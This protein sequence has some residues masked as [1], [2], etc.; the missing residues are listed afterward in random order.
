M[1]GAYAFQRINH[2][3]SF[4]NKMCFCL[5]GYRPVALTSVAMTT[6][7]SFVLTHLESLL[8][9]TFDPFQFVYRANRSSGEAISAWLH[10]IF[11]HLEKKGSYAGTH[12]IVYNSTSD[13]I[14]PA[15][16]H[17]KLLTDLNF[18]VTICDWIL[19][20]LSCHRHTVKVGNFAS[21]SNFYVLFCQAL[22]L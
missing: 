17:Y 9:A 21:R 1:W 8:S 22:H 20:S 5:D 6:F 13:A 3:S 10:K 2:Y 18:P 15:K 4:K 19:Y 12:F 11:A 7:E 14:N 16:L